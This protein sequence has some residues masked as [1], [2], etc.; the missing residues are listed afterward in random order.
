MTRAFPWSRLGI[1]PT[2]DAGAIRKAYAD[3]LRATNVDEDIAGYAELRRARD[4]ALWLAKQADREEEEDNFGL[5]DLDDEGGWNEGDWDGDDGA[6]DVAPGIQPPLPGPEPQLSPGQLRT[7]AAWKELH[8][9]LYPDGEPSDEAVTHAELDTGLAALDALLI[10]AEEADLAEH[11]ALDDALAELF[12][13]TWPRSA[14]FV[15][16]ANTA[17]HW[18][19]EA[20]ALEERPALRFL[21]QRLKGMRFHEKVQQP[22]HPL[23]KAWTE[24][25]RPGKAGMLDRLKVKRVEVDKLLVGIRQRYPEL[26]SLLDPQRVASW[27]RD[28]ALEGSPDGTGPN[29]VRWIFILVLVGSFL[30]RLGSA[31][32][33]RDN[34]GDQ[35]SEAAVA[36]ALREANFV[37]A[38]SAIFG[39]GTDVAAVRKADPP[40]AYQL[41]LAMGQGA[42]PDAA[43]AFARNKAVQS[44]EVAEFDALVA[45]A[46]LKQLWLFA[47]IGS[48]EQCRQVL[49]GDFQSQPLELDKPQRAREIQLLRQLL[50][51]GVLGHRGKAAERTLSVPGWMIEEAMERTGLGPEALGAALRDPAHPE[52]CRVELALRTA[53]LKQPGR[54]PV[55][56]L[57]WL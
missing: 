47:A 8:G 43:L 17:F 33:E 35:P 22:D 3:A 7:Q 23:H 29:V 19:D 46:E 21:N 53:M 15:E 20:G 2:S 36:E 55:E 51:A 34:S 31:M 39:E 24:L 27:D 40:F 16:P 10:R 4:Q 18:L 5:G 50:D 28:G 38:T 37:V 44:A 56:L 57:R 54:V 32:S 25:S 49:E 11:D 1:D 14:P 9:V 41:R 12:A 30:A 45:L 6:W 42:T 48:R 26:E 52:R 13:R